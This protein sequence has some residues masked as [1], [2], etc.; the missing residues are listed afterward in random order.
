MFGTTQPAP[1][2]Q[3]KDDFAGIF[4]LRKPSG[5]L[6]QKSLRKTLQRL[7]QGETY[8]VD[9]M[10]GQ[11]I[12]VKFSE[13]RQVYVISRRRWV[14]GTFFH[15][16][17]CGVLVLHGLE[18]E[19]INGRWVMGWVGKKVSPKNSTKWHKCE[20]DLAF[21]RLE[22]GLLFLVPT[23]STTWLLVLEILISGRV[24]RANGHIDGWWQDERLNHFWAEGASHLRK[25]VTFDIPCCNCQM[26][27]TASGQ[28]WNIS[29]TIQHT[30]GWK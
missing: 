27:A 1:F 6:Y 7:K 4:L 24:D 18:L 28:S 22:E 13:N 19:R 9:N 8:W 23:G 11:G 30:P 16:V 21:S 12:R 26:V 25:S 20:V 29:Q 15:V 10:E 14:M 2:F 5:S 3:W 17:W